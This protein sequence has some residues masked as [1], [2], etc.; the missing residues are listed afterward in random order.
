MPQDV[1]FEDWED[2]EW[3]DWEDV[4][5]EVMIEKPIRDREFQGFKKQIHIFGKTGKY[6]GPIG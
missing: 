5:F 2:V 6:Y 3:A 4:I 1:I